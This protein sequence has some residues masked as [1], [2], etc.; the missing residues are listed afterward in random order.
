MAPNNSERRDSLTIMMDLLKNMS[1]PIKL[2]PLLYNT[3]LNYSQLKRYLAA[4]IHLGWIQEIRE[5]CHGYRIAEKGK[6][7]LQLLATYERKDRDARYDR[8]FCG[9]QQLSI[10]KETFT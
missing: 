10:M 7:F 3:N 4:L 9:V 6:E 5:P 2:T 8:L 1:Q